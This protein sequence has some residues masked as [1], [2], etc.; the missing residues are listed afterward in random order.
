MGKK[1]Y[2]GNMDYNTTQETLEATFGEFG[3]VTSVKII[4][5]HVTGRPKGFAFIEMETEEAAQNAIN[6]LN[7]KDL[8][9]RAL[10]VNEAHD[11][12][13]NKRPE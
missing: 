7:G 6:A 4:T 5:D 13:F 12:P 11:K 10:R 1:I 3:A 8:D 9:G 2:V